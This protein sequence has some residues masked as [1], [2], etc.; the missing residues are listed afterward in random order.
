MIIAL[1]RNPSRYVGFRAES[2]IT[3]GPPDGDRQ[4]WCGSDISVVLPPL[5][6]IMPA[7]GRYG[8]A[9]RAA[10]GAARGPV[11]A[12]RSEPRQRQDHEMRLPY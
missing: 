3:G 2:A 8:R 4:E 9:C 7:A 11:T 10:A 5:A 6:L 1:A 12:T